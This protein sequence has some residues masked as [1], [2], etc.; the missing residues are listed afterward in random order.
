MGRRFIDSQE[1]SLHCDETTSCGLLVCTWR[2]PRNPSDYS[3]LPFKWPKPKQF[4]FLSD[5]YQ[6]LSIHLTH[7][8]SSPKS[9]AQGSHNSILLHPICHCL[10][11]CHLPAAKAASLLNKH[12]LF[13]NLCHWPHS[14]HLHSCNGRA[15]GAFHRKRSHHPRSN[16]QQLVHKF[17]IIP[18]LSDPFCK[19]TTAKQSGISE[20]QT[21]SRTL[22]SLPPGFPTAHG[23]PIELAR[24]KCHPP[25][26]IR[27]RAE[28]DA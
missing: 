2:P 10:A 21:L 28:G 11:G 16:S 9:L 5:T 20:L 14:A 3:R 4:E 1:S 22:V 12:Q 6:S 7:L 27:A 8:S 17:T 26:P 13:D 24:G 18:C 23:A 25:P 19:T 15:L